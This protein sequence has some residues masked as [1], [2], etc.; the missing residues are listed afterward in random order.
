V[1]TFRALVAERHD[2]RVERRVDALG[3]DDLPDGEVTV[4]VAW[5]S[6]NYKDALAVSPTGRVARISPLVPGIDLAGEVTASDAPEFRP[7]DRV[8]AHGYDL[9]VSHFGGFAE[10]A[11]VPAGWVVP[12]PD[13]LSLRQA[14]ALGTAGYTAALSVQELEERGLEPGAGPVLVLG[15]SGGVGST[16]VGILAARGY[17]V[18]ASTGKPEAEGFLRELGAAEVLSREETS[19]E[20][21]RPLERARWAG[22]V[23]PVGGASLAYALRTLAQGGAVAASGNTGGPELRTTVLPFILRGVALLGVDSAH[24]PIERRR[25]VWERLAGDLRPRGLDESITREVPLDE[26]DA[27]LDG[28]LA[29]KGQG[30]TVVRIGAQEPGTGPAA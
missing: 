8:L 27:L 11:R 2:D 4:R 15:A 30:R 10:Y 24:T 17:Q 28:V 5:S 26:L 22:C 1:E 7:G 23:D 3:L 13:G 25:R 16:A 21:S 29:G 19:T 18:A 9:G 20:S 12:L 6:V 14:M